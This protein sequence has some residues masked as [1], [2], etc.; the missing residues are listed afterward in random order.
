MTFYQLTEGILSE[1]LKNRDTLE[2]VVEKIITASTRGGIAFYPCSKYTRMIVTEIKK[3][4]PEILPKVI[5]FYDKSDEADIG[6]EIKINNIR[7]LNESVDRISLLIV[8]SNTY[9]DR[10]LKDIKELTKYN[11]AV[12]KTS[13]FDIS[14]TEDIRNKEIIARFKKVYDL[15]ADEKSKMTY[16][17]T[18]LSKL[19][20]DESSTYI[21]EADKDIVAEYKGYKLQGIDDAYKKENPTDLYEMRY[22]TL[23]KGDVVF[24]IGAFRGD[25]AAIFANC[26]GMSGR[27]Y[28]FEPHKE[29]YKFLLE[30][31]RLN[32]LND[33]VIPVNKGCSNKSQMLELVSVKAG[34]A[35]SFLSEKETGGATEVISVDDF[36]DINSINRV[37]FIKM[38]VEGWE[39]NVLRG[40]QK[41]IKRFKPKMAITLYHN[42]SDLFTI[43]ILVSELDNYELYMRCK[44]SGP[45]GINL[46]CKRK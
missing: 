2:K 8:A 23:D 41:T 44:I 46:Y 6:P 16:L 39:E 25:T 3:K 5:G 42:T 20:N 37:N 40:A 17:I 30:N 35:W 29:N 18:W 13:Y 36:V 33:I 1:R 21:F 31:I 7:T 9:Y 15:L 45:Y 32:G 4:A 11:G 26:V 43:P 14:L 10:E 22:V 38:D 19:T 28:S 12:I 34:A 27:V 24:D